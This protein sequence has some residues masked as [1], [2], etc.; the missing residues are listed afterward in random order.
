MGDYLKNEQSN[1]ETI[2]EKHIVYEKESKNEKNDSEGLNG[3]LDKFSDILDS[4]LKK[5]KN[6]GY[7]NINENREIED[8]FDNSSTLEKMA[9]NMIVSKSSKDANFKD[10]GGVS[11]TKKDKGKTDSTIDLLSGLDN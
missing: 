11:K 6:V 8:D 10:L 1:K 3:L 5:I 9:D 4:K 2:V 7:Q